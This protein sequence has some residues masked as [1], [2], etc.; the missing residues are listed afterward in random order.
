MA[1]LRE[2][3]YLYLWVITD[4]NTPLD[5]HYKGLQNAFIIVLVHYRN[6]SYDDLE[7]GSTVHHLKGIF[8]ITYTV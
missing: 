3:N 1:L 4:L 5:R 2:Y 6:S 7:I 8:L